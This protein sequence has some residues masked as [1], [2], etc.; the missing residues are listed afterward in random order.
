[1]W[2]ALHILSFTLFVSLEQISSVEGDSLGERGS[3]L[4]QNLERK[5]EL[6]ILGDTESGFVSQSGQVPASPSVPWRRFLGPWENQPPVSPWRE[7]TA[8]GPLLET[9]PRHVVPT[10]VSAASPGVVRPAEAASWVLC[11]GVMAGL[12]VTPE[13]GSCPRAGAASSML[14]VPS[15]PSL[16]P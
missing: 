1:M 8:E 7:E 3:I 11:W 13:R 4:S 14:C 6:H 5:A 9:C 15:L 10:Q 12:A 16:L 2:S